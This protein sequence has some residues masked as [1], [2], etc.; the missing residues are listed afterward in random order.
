M[1]YLCPADQYYDPAK[2]SAKLR[3]MMS[4]GDT[5]EL[6]G[7][8]QELL[9]QSVANPLTQAILAPL[10]QSLA[11]P[12]SQYFGNM[13]YSNARKETII[14]ED[15]QTETSNRLYPQLFEIHGFV[16]VRTAI[17]EDIEE[18]DI[19][20]S[21]AP[22]HVTIKGD[23][24]GNDHMIP[25]PPGTKKEGAVAAFKDRVLEIKI[26]REIKAEASEEITVDYL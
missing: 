25:L 3:D 12:L 4:K 9:M 10:A 8:I 7:L 20:I 13:N 23:P 18:R 16:I 17:P 21:I 26:P 1:I 22:S 15:I 11:L 5:A 14:K 19:K 2:I 24:S 6:P